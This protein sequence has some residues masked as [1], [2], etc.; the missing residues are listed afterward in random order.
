MGRGL[1]GPGWLLFGDSLATDGR[2]KLCLLSQLL[3]VDDGLDLYRFAA[4]V[5]PRCCQEFYAIGY[6]Y[7]QGLVGVFFGRD[8]VSNL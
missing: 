2:L 6:L 4:F 7:L 3:L 5:G 8:Y 1:G